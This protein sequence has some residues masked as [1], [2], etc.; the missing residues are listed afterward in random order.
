MLQLTGAMTALVT[1][2]DA[3]G[4]VDEAALRR[5]VDFQI[6]GGI[7]GIVAVGTTGESATLSHAE[8]IEIFKI[9]KEQSA[10]RV[11]IIAG[12]GGNNTAVSVDMTRAAMEVGVDAAL[13]VVPYYNKPSQAGLIHHFTAVAEVGLPVVLYNVPGRTVISMSPETVGALA[14]LPSVVSIKE[15]TGDMR[16][17][18]EVMAAG[19]DA[20][21][22][23]SGDDFTTFP[24]VT[25]GG[26]GCV[27][28]VSNLAPGLLHELV[29]AGRAGDLSRGQALNQKVNRL[30]RL[31]F[32]DSNPTPSKAI[33]SAMGL[34]DEFVR[35]PLVPV[36]EELK[37][38]LVSAAR[39]EGLL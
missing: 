27:S 33:L 24:F 9:V 32:S 37:E 16:Y 7:D 22:Y 23:L 36:S 18:A 4:R 28:V 12:T 1:P 14:A 15:A 17:G 21:T 13:V 2:F 35:G 6:D 25:I 10:G 26:D 3:E 29:E 8:K 39:E 20:I 31:C 34:C 30:A 5:L 38:R 11:P 19:G